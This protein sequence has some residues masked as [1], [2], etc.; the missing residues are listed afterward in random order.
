MK[1][2][3]MP[4]LAALALAGAPSA[5]LAQKCDINDSK[6]FQVNSA[7]I[8]L[9]KATSPSGKEDERP[10]HLKNAIEV[11]TKD[12]DR[13]G[14]PVGRAYLLG[15]TLF[16]WT[17]QPGIGFTSTRG[18]IGYTDNPGQPVDLL[19]A[20]DSAFSVVEAGAPACADS[21][22]KF[23]SAISNK[24]FNDAV[25][26]INSQQV[27]SAEVLVRKSRLLTPNS[28]YVWNALAIIEE[29]RGRTDSLPT[30]YAKVLETTKGDTAF[31]KLR[32]SAMFNL[33]IVKM[34]QADQ[35][36]GE[37]K[38]AALTEARTLLQQYDTEAPGNPNT[39]RALARAL[40]ALG[41]TAA[42]TQ[43]YASMLAD[44]S[45]YSEVQLFEA[46]AALAIARK[47]A[48]AVKLFDAALALNPYNRDGLFNLAST[49]SQAGDF[50]AM[51]AAAER[52]V[53][54][55]PGNPDSWQQLAVAY[56]GL[57]RGE[58]NDVRKKAW[59]DSLIKYNQKA[60]TAPLRVQVTQ[61]RHA[62][63]RH[64]VSGTVQNL[65]TS[66]REVTLK[67]EFLDR[68]GTVVAS[69]EAKVGSV[70]PGSASPFTV[71]VEQAGVVGYRYAPPF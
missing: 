45:K 8:Y 30:F 59:V 12:G 28:P 58:K 37:A 46:A 53:A 14:N 2:P 56:Q 71:V 20:I 15:R 42:A 52:L 47:N 7:R 5:V 33:A 66:P 25:A 69:Q 70:A 22:G 64:S 18:R 60:K 16:V 61:L 27:D 43:A 23:R 31:A 54:V 34:T 50:A 40:S 6:P 35:L 57:S 13:I 36:S 55:D 48:D 17:Q 41:D 65:G 4:A 1:N 29:R 19:A 9:N 3:V 21:V 49:Y 32:Q 62:G 44:P 51:R 67:F 38:R 24:L 11:L 26:L 63:A 39:Q 68:S 10:R